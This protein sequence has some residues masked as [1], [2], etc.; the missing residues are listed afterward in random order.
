[1]KIMMYSCKDMKEDYVGCIFLNDINEIVIM[2]KN[3]LISF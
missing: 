1:M 2:V 3:I